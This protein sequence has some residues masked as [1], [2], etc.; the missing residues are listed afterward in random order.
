[1]SNVF[2]RRSRWL[3]L[4]LLTIV[5]IGCVKID[6]YYV[7]G[8]RQQ[9][10]RLQELLRYLEQPY[11]SEQATLTLYELISNELVD[12]GYP[13]R[14]RNFLMLHI[15]QNPDNI[16]NAYYLYLIATSY[17][18]NSQQDIARYYL[19]QN[20]LEPQRCGDRT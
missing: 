4:L 12:T 10:Q 5:F 7:V 11:L 13:E 2:C 1:M 14:M 3:A 15:E 17:L 16:Y 18:Q 9:R 20:N 6:S 19:H 8:E